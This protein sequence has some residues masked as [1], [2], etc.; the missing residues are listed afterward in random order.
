MSD[1]LEIYPFKSR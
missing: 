1:L